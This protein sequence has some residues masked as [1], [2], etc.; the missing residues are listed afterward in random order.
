M[1]RKKAL[2]FTLSLLL[3]VVPVLQMV[4]AH[5][6]AA[7]SANI[8]ISEVAPDGSTASQE[9][10]EL[11]NNSDS[12]VVVQGWTVQLRSASGAI[13]RTLSFGD[14]VIKA[15][16]YALFAST[17]YTTPCT[18]ADFVCFTAS[19][20]ASG[21]HVVL[22]NNSGLVVDKLG[23]GTANDPETAAAATPLFG[24]ASLTRK[25]VSNGS[26]QDTDNNSNDFDS[27][28]AHTPSGGG[29]Y[30]YVPIVDVCPNLDGAQASV[31]AGYEQVGGLCQLIV[32]SPPTTI[33]PTCPGVVITEILPNPS[34]DDTG[35][36]YVELFNSLNTAVDVTGCILNVGSTQQALTGTIA[37][38][39]TA[40]Y[41]LTLPNAAGGQVQLISNV[42]T[43][44]ITYP[45]NLKDDEAYGLVGNEWKAGLTPTP[46]AINIDAQAAVMGAE[47]ETAS[48][49]C[50]AGKYRNP[51]TGRCKN[52]DLDT[53]PTPCGPGQTRNP[54]TN[55]CRNAA[56]ATA[57]VTPCQ[58]GETRNPETNRCR[59][60]TTASAPTACQPG[61]ERNPETN[62]CRKVLAAKSTNPMSKTGAASSKPI[63]FLVLGAVAALVGGYAVYEY[64]QSIVNFIARRRDDVA[65]R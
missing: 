29:T 47:S 65:V 63:S 16:A 61:Q 42:Q 1:T 18:N 4:I 37:P 58:T 14:K 36:E 52:F 55:R 22:L 20:S 51:E 59:K 56:T 23:W 30:A 32:V 40:I 11:Y 27:F 35:K 7:A 8:I 46:G 33:V 19:M 44:T 49:Q 38:G 25:S 43:Q 5:P 28:T 13:N 53:G 15:R 41:G 26:L 57:T 50:P 24:A 17:G 21:G 54:D 62:R 34:G 3:A 60:N 12:D 64:R 10:V 9:F 2:Q 39:Y 48:D 31:P 6:A 45:A